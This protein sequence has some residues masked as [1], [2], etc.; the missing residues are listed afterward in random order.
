[1]QDFHGLFALK[2]DGSIPI[3]GKPVFFEAGD[4][5]EIILA[6]P[7]ASAALGQRSIETGSSL[8][9]IALLKAFE[10]FIKALDLGLDGIG[11]IGPE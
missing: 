1:L 6:R 10:R 5:T 2:H 3:R 11:D 9:E 8:G 4:F 7:I